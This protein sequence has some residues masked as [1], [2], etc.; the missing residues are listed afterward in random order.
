MHGQP[1]YLTDRCILPIV[2]T[3]TRE[4]AFQIRGELQAAVDYYGYDDVELLID[5]PGG[6]LAALDGLLADID[7]LQNECVRVRTAVAGQAA[8]AA[9]FLLAFGTVGHRRACPA[10]RILIHEP[11][12][13]LGSNG[14][15]HLWTRTEL[16]RAASELEDANESLI[17]RL[18][19]HV[20]AGVG[21]NGTLALR[22]SADGER[23]VR[24][25][26][27]LCRAYRRLLQE[28]RWLDPAGALNLQLIDSIG[29]RPRQSGRLS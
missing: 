23:V 18:A 27:A 15:D 12:A 20:R 11:R 13:A 7:S 14:R 6:E 24:T 17:T 28:E 9:A 2:G 3:I 26:T 1:R 21:K 22:R 5:S 4:T 25:E 19:R 10:S 8:S 16:A 29:A